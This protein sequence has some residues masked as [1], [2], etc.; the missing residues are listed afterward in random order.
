MTKGA[1]IG[2]YG[3]VEEVT[4]AN[5]VLRTGNRNIVVDCGLQHGRTYDDP[6]PTDETLPSQAQLFGYEPSAMDTLLV[7]HAHA[8]HIG[9]IPRFVR[10]G[11]SGT[12]WSTQATKDLAAVMLSDAQSILA[13]EARE[14]GV[15][16][17]YETADIQRAL[18]QWKTRE[19]HQSWDLGDGVE[20]TFLDAGHI[21]GSAM[22]QLDRAG[23]RIVFTGDLGNSPAPL[24]PNTEKIKNVNYL[25]MESVYGNRNHEPREKSRRELARA[26]RNIVDHSG[27]LLIPS[28][29]LQR[30]QILIHEIHHLFESGRVKPV[31]VYL[32]SPLA[33]KVTEIFYRHRHL[34]NAR[35]QAEMRGGERIFDYPHFVEVLTAEESYQISKKKGPKII[36]ASSGMSVGGRVREHEKALLGDKRTIFLFVGYQARGT[37]GRLIQDGAKKLEI[38][39][40]RVRVR[41]DIRSLSGFSA[42]K[43]RDNL[44][45]FVSDSAGTLEKV[46][47]VMGDP[48]S[49]RSLA[50]KIK[51]DLNLNAVTQKRG[52]LV[53]IDF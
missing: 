51:A 46:F 8:D 49:S 1:S 43:D 28:F 30:T 23:R 48:D 38:D 22:V 53:N 17:L 32:D 50:Q 33:A 2:F 39:G 5:F 15:S 26:I 45:R 6:P 52:D 31:P 47:V 10:D 20:A 21:L 35:I 19:Y 7:T 41:A 9:R 29:A 37:L 25:V 40:R 42:H 16:P 3:G 24:L 18:R 44:V 13:Q 36:L 14:R 12:I 27:T 11:F 4:G 34:F